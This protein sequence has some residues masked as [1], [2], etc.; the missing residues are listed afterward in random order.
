MLA[1]IIA[2]GIGTRFWP[3]STPEYPKQFLTL[4]GDKSMLQ[5]TFER[6]NTFIHKEDI[7]IV[8]TETHAE[9][10]AEQL[11]QIQKD[12]IIIEPMGMNT[13]P[14]IGMSCVYLQQKYE[15]ERVLIL[16]ADHYI[17]DTEAFKQ[18][19][20]KTQDIEDYIVTFGI[21]PTYPATGYGYIQAGKPY[22]DDFFSV[23]QFKEKP[24]LY[25]AN[26]MLE[27]G[28]YYWNSG[29]FYSD[30]NTILYAYENHCPEVL[31]L[32]N[33]YLSTQ[34]ETQKRDIYAQMPKLPFDIVIMEKSNN[35]L[36][37]PISYVW[38]DVGNWRSLSELMENDIN[39]NYFKGQS[40]TH[41]S[42]NNSIYS[43][44]YVALLGVSD[45]ILVETDEAI[46]VVKKEMAE[47]VK[48]VRS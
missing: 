5:L 31:S 15:N 1:L 20:H 10:V 33:K 44:K 11:P 26:Q 13:A 38:S 46:L 27:I 47:K 6:V 18:S 17:P 24:S 48:E 30:L 39:G 40:Y 43:K 21:I 28:N 32:S 4:F 22:N 2:G 29:M 16:P 41:E 14:C 35:V 12:N 45:I 23:C 34:D 36:V 19:I 8:T 3:L 37:L 25:V 9:L 42:V 7:Y